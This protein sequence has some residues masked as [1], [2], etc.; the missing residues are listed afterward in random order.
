MVPM[1]KKLT[2]SKLLTHDER[3]WLNAYHAEVYTKTKHF[4]AT[5]SLVIRWLQWETAPLGL[6]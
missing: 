3:E 5:D 2:D 1:C 4:F 6:N